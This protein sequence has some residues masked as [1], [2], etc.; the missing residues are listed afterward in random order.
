M[1]TARYN[2]MLMLIAAVK[3]TMV[4]MTMV[5][6]IAKTMIITMI[7]ITMIM[8]MAVRNIDVM[9]NGHYKQDGGSLFAVS[10][11]SEMKLK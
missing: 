5:V 11:V 10:S 9:H 3:I 4:K 1:A 6:V 7:N 8:M 2:M